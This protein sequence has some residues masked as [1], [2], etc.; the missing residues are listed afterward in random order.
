MGRRGSVV[1]LA[2]WSAGRGGKRSCTQRASVEPKSLV[3]RL[4][5]LQHAGLPARVFLWA[6]RRPGSA[7]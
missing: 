1:L 4:T 3:K 5:N 2:F 6:N 7:S